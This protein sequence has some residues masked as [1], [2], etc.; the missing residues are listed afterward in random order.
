MDFWAS[1]IVSRFSEKLEIQHIET[2]LKK[3]HHQNL[4]AKYIP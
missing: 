2:L 3:H 1:V 4:K